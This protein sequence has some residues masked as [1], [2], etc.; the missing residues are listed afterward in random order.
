M[1]CA[2]YN[3]LIIPENLRNRNWEKALAWLKGDCWKS[4][5]EGLT[6]I[7]GMKVYA[8]RST[9]IAKPFCECRYESHR[10]YADI[11]MAIKGSALMLVCMRDGLKITEP[12][13]SEKDIDFLGGEPDPVHRIA[14]VFPLA[15]VLFPWDVHMPDIA[16]D[17]NPCEIE[18]LVIKVAM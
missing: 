4:I 10:I 9:R 13:S 5:P 18:K 8:T 1:I 16:Q 11:Q 6:E 3:E 14:L 2:P 17:D 15:A 7:D 12:Y